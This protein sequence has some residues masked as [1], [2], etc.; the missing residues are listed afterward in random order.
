MLA[1]PYPKHSTSV[2]PLQTV[3][4]H[5]SSWPLRATHSAQTLPG[6]PVL[7]LRH[8]QPRTESHSESPLASVNAWLD[9]LAPS[10]TRIPRCRDCPFLLVSLHPLNLVGKVPANDESF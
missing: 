3:Y 4:S 5:A 6:G 7:P 1:C 10:S 8:I 9:L 2:S